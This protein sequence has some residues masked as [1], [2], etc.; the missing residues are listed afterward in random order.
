[1]CI[2]FMSITH[3]IEKIKQSFL[4]LDFVS[5]ITVVFSL[6]CLMLSVESCLRSNRQRDDGLIFA[7]VCNLIRV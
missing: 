5:V 6:V 7:G 3:D 1:M 4:S 2:T